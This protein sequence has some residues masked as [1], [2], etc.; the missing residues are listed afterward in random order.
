[1]LR[2]DSSLASR[3]I[4]FHTS[5][6]QNAWI[7]WLTGLWTF[8][9]LSLDTVLYHVT[10][11]WLLETCSLETR[12]TC[13][14]G[15]LA[16]GGMLYHTLCFVK[17]NNLTVHW[18][19]QGYFFMSSTFRSWRIW[20]L[21]G[22]WKQTSGHPLTPETRNLNRAGTSLTDL[23]IA[24]YITQ[25]LIHIVFYN[26]LIRFGLSVPCGKHHPKSVW[27]NT[28]LLAPCRRLLTRS[29][30]KTRTFAKTS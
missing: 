9:T 30:H 20:R 13:K 16:S 19:L 29:L 7:L 3:S 4:R 15:S 24:S 14:Y 11:H 1:M 12:S 17:Y 10:P 2:S 25:L 18:P 8:T 28:G 6:E 5:L 23:M 27:K 21:T 22:L 26:V